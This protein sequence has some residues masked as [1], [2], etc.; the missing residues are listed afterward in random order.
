MADAVDVAYPASGI[1]YRNGR[2]GIEGRHI[3]RTTYSFMR[4]TSTSRQNPIGP[5]ILQQYQPTP[6]SAN[7]RSNATIF[8]SPLCLMAAVAQPLLMWT[9][10]WYIGDVGNQIVSSEII[11]AC[12][13]DIAL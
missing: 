11:L 1:K 10:T 4:E 5:T 3:D 2:Y 12:I 6:A 13:G 9:R 7:R 8:G